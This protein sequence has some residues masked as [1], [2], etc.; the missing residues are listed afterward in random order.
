MLPALVRNSQRSIGATASRTAT[1]G[2]T[3]V[4]RF[5]RVAKTSRVV[6]LTQL[7]T[8][9]IVLPVFYEFKAVRR[10]GKSTEAWKTS[11][12]AKMLS[13]LSFR[14]FCLPRHATATFWLS[15]CLNCVIAS[16]LQVLTW[17]VDAC[18]TKP[19]TDVICDSVISSGPIPW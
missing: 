1:R 5:A 10:Q 8:P 19:K 11:W 15:L 4:S 12:N 2:Q 7:A 6:R 13:A 3:S 14:I 18:L 9:F 17:Q 16:N